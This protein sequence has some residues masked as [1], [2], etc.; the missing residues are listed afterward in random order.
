M[1]DNNL[2]LATMTMDNGAKIIFE[3]YPEHAPLACE[4]FIRLANQGKYD[5]RPIERIVP[6]F[7]IQPSYNYFDDPEMNFDID[8]EF[9]AAG[10]TNGLSNDKFSVALAGDG[11]KIS[12]GSEFFFTLKYDPRLDGRFTTFGKVISGW[13]EIERLANLPLI[14]VPCDVPDVIINKPSVE[15]VI[16]SIRV[17]GVKN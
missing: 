8:G 3:L 13:D 11:K 14:S 12:S 6:D 10:Y 7:V 17:E 1:S 15:Q 2:P 5:N 9:S 16:K 4:S